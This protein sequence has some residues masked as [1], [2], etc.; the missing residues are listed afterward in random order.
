MKQLIIIGLL[1][2]GLS[3][4]KL[5]PRSSEAESMKDNQER[6]GTLKDVAIEGEPAYK[7]NFIKD[8]T[9]GESDEVLIWTIGG[10]TVDKNNRVYIASGKRILVFDEHQNFIKQIGRQ[11][12]GPGEFDNMGGLQPKIA[13]QKLHVYDDVLQRVNVFGLTNLEFQYTIPIN[14]ENWSKYPDLKHSRFKN[15]FSFKDSLL[16]VGFKEILGRNE[17]DIP[18]SRY[19]LMNKEGEIVSNEI[20]KIEDNGFYSGFG[21]PGPIKLGASIGLPQS[22]SSIVDV[23]YKG[24]IYSAW[25]EDFRIEIINNE[26]VKMDISYPMR[27]A[28]LDKSKVLDELNR[29]RRSKKT[30]TYDTFPET[31]PAIDYFF[32]DDEDRIWVATIVDDNENFE[33]MV[34]STQGA[35]LAKFLWPGQR[36]KRHRAPREIKMVVNNYLYTQENNTD[37]GIDEVIRYKIEFINNFA[38]KD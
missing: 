13:S 24:N 2:L 4:C 22:R 19:Y 8:G 29:A 15:Y 1:L 31:W 12:R 6:L 7:I 17:Q 21:T 38:R 35:L 23:D 28:E 9:F 5:T 26:G 34:I 16:L 30:V 33:W 18:F 3:G 37:T 10:F 25:T 11:G 36:L 27:N 14:P 20:F 32:V